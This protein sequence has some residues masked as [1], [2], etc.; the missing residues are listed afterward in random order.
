[1]QLEQYEN[2]A[3]A[4]LFASGEPLPQKRLAAALEIEED[5]AASVL[6][7]LAARYEKND[8][9]IE[10][11]RLDD[12]WQLCSRREYAPDIRSALELKRS[13]PLSQAA[14][15]VLA[16]IA[17]NQPVTRGFVEQV[18]GVDCS[19]VVATLC[20]KGLIEEGD[21]L[22]LPGRPIAYRTTSV[23]LRCF[24]LSSLEE[25]PPVA[26]ETGDDE[27]TLDDT[28]ENQQSLFAEEN[29]ENEDFSETA[30]TL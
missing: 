24:G 4:I 10:L 23:F 19:G 30:E 26:E 7:S 9:A 12:C 6:E 29:E 27:K 8:S 18:R 3:E 25:L 5:A 20:D 17:Y 14:L 28:L 15:E 2:R 11:L 16:V 22:D 13:I 21:R 1:M